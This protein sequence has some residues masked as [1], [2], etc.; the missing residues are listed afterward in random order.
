MTKP[1]TFID[2][3][4][5][6]FPD[7]YH[8]AAYMNYMGWQFGGEFRK[9]TGGSFASYPVTSLLIP[10]SSSTTTNSNDG[11]YKP[12]VTVSDFNGDGLQDIVGFS[13]AGGGTFLNTG[14][15]FEKSGLFSGLGSVETILADF[16]GD[17]LPDKIADYGS[18]GKYVYLNNGKGWNITPEL[19]MKI[20]LEIT[21][22]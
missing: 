14:K 8:Y 3:N 18:S 20:P 5:D 9:N 10:V 16:N 19:G 11:Y 13:P 12:Y 1:W 17:G 22:P 6:Y 21:L 7:T 15:N 4:G 2:V